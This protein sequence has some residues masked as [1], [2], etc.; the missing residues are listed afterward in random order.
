MRTILLLL[1]TIVSVS[2]QQ[3]SV[4]LTWDPPPETGIAGYRL[5][6]GLT[7]GIYTNTINVSATRHTV[8]NLVF[9]ARYFFAV[10]AVSAQGLES[11]YS[12]ELPFLV[13]SKPSAPVISG[14]M[15]ITGQITI[16]FK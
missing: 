2:A 7:S 10:T 15:N 5:Y 1:L 11:G 9:G 13:P 8:T 4:T 16:E 6:S 14:T 3:A 12:N